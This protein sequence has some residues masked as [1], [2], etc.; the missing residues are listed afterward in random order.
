MSDTTMRAKAL[1]E[2][3]T[4]GLWT[5]HTAPHP[6]SGETHAEYLAGTLIGSG[7]PLHVVTAPSPE[8]RYAYIVPAVTGDGPTSAR[9]AEFIAAAPSL[10]RELVAEIERFTQ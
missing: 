8:D 1:L 9:N 3:I 10:I 6:D 5:H 2:G 7:E 4:P